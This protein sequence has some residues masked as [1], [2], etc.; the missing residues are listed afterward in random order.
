MQCPCGGM[1]KDHE[2]VRNKVVVGNY[3]K[4]KRCGRIH[5][6]WLTDDLLEEIEE[7]QWK[8]LNAKSKK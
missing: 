8:S 2:V 4:C 5:W 7:D 6:W 3:A 1:T